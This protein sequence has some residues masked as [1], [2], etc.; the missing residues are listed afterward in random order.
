MENT[1]RRFQKLQCLRIFGTSSPVDTTQHTNFQ[2]L[3][4][5]KVFFSQRYPSYSFCKMT[6]SDSE[7]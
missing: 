6:L 1:Y 4:R 5:R 3:E 7:C 2:T